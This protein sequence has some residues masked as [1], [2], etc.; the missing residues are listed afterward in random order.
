[1][2]RPIAHYS[3]RAPFDASIGGKM[4]LALALVG[5]G[6]ESEMPAQPDAAAT[7]TGREIHELQRSSQMEVA[8]VVE[9]NGQR[10]FVPRAPYVRVAEVGLGTTSAHHQA[11]IDL[12][13][14]DEQ[15]SVKEPLAATVT[16]TDAAR[17]PLTSPDGKWIRSD[18]EIPGLGMTT[19][20]L[21]TREC[22]DDKMPPPVHN[23][24][25][26]R[27]RAVWT[28]A[29]T[30]LELSCRASLAPT[31]SG[32]R[33]MACFGGSAATPSQP[34]FGLYGGVSLA[35]GCQRALESLASSFSYLPSIVADWERGP[36][37]P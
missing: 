14:A 34:A 24:P 3:P 2:R 4:A 23:M 21:D 33:P 28:I 9:A 5:S 11:W 29:D 16:F 17:L 12:K 15:D 13:S 36:P 7:L 35:H 37:T 8:R 19:L 31:P 18:I 6:C 20:W 25:D 1:M 10:Y 30:P 32:K 22:S 26:L 27:I